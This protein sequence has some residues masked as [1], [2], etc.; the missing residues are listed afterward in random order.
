MEEKLLRSGFKKNNFWSCLQ[1]GPEDI[2]MISRDQEEGMQEQG[3][4]VSYA[5]DSSWETVDYNPNDDQE[6][7]VHSS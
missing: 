2:F 1:I 4:E 7:V 3:L 5:D 6:N